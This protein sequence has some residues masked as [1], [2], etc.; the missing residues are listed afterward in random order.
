[1]GDHELQALVEGGSFFEGPRWHDGTW[2]VSDFYR[3]QVMTVGADGAEQVVMEVPGQPSCLGWT[4]DGSLLVVSMTDHVVLRRDAD[5][6]VSTHADIGD[7][8]AGNLNDM[9][10]DSA[11]R[12]WVGGFGFDLMGGADPVP[13]SL[14]R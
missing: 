13:A 14:V 9:V 2:W 5:G 10:V 12:A 8:I 4:P 3:H 7:R 11:G 6:T 1:M